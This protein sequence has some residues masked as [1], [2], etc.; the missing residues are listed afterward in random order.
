MSAPALRFDGKVA[1][2]TAGAAGIGMASARLFSAG[3]ARVAICDVDPAA[4]RAAIEELKRNGADALFIEADLSKTQ[5]IEGVVRRVLS[6]YRN[7]DILVNNAGGGRPGGSIVD[8]SEADWDW[9]FDLCLKATWLFMRHVLPGM[10]AQGRGA[11]VNVSSLAGIRVAPNSSPAYAASKAGVVHLTRF[12]AV[13]YAAQGIRV[14]VVSPGLTATAS[15]MNALSAEERTHIVS[16]LHAIPRLA[17]P[18]ET[19][20]TIA[21]LCSDAA[22]IVTGLNVPVDGGWSAR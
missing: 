4:G 22:P 8:Q 11:I 10:V 2:V 16:G 13:Q 21:W 6:A 17:E 15:V 20:A 5:Q 19:A 12:A 18:E 1:L 3:G 14:N 9:T 7:I